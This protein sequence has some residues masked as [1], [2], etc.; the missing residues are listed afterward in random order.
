MKDE[1]QRE[2]AEQFLKDKGI[3]LDDYSIHDISGHYKAPI[4]IIEWLVEFAEQQQ[5]LQGDKPKLSESTPDFTDGI[6]NTITSNGMREMTKERFCQAVKELQSLQG[7]QQTLTEDEKYVIGVASDLLVSCMD[8]EIMIQRNID[9]G[10]IYK[11]SGM[12]K[13]L[14]NP[15]LPS[16]E[17]CEVCGNVLSDDEADVCDKCIVKLNKNIRP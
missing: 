4:H 13:D 1:E 6:F 11:I 2:R 9:V 14:G 16:D 10:T 3:N 5:S 17:F 7:E 15:K 12:I 8:G